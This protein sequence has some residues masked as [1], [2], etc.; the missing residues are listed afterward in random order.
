MTK[1]DYVLIARV[2]KDA[3]DGM[4]NGIITEPVD[5]IASHLCE[6]LEADNPRFN[7]EQFLSACGLAVSVPEAIKKV[8]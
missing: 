6:I 5:F 1:K 7:R 2:I 3:N 4:K 8:L